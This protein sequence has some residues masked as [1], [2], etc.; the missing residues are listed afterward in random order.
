MHH[1][2]YWTPQKIARRLTL[3]APL[4][5]R[6]RQPLPSFR[7]TTLSGPLEDPPV[8]L[9][10]DDSQWEAIEPNTYWGTWMT[11][12]TMRARFTVPAGWQA[13][14]ALYLPIGNSGDFSHPEALAYIDGEPYA[15]AD[16][17][18]HEIRLSDRWCD[19]EPHLLALHGWTGLGG[20]CVQ[21]VNREGS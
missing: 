8:G 4:I 19:G 1:Q 12:F 14:T 18:H 3:I 10:M 17:H 7:Y 5:Y 16:R 13:P 15:A 6:H 9:D 20:V 11:D 2:T 21:G